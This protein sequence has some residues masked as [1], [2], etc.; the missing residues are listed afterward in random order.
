M[1]PAS[2]P[3]IVIR[4]SNLESKWVLVTDRVYSH[5]LIFLPAD[6]VANCPEQ[7]LLQP[8]LIGQHPDIQLILFTPLAEPRIKHLTDQFPVGTRYH[9]SCVACQVDAWGL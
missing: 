7:V 3:A 1:D 9:T 4:E 5:N 2:L 6:H 8:L